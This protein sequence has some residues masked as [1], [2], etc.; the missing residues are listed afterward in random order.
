MGIIMSTFALERI[1]KSSALSGLVD[2]TMVEQQKRIK[3]AYLGGR[4]G[5]VVMG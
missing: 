2:S 4:P 3:K 1:A 5:L